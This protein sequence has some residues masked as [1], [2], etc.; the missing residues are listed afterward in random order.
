M[1]AHERTIAYQL[2]EY[3]EWMKT[4]GYAD[5]TIRRQ[6]QCMKPFLSFLKT[7]GLTDITDITY[8][9]LAEYAASLTEYTKKDGDPLSSAT[10]S[11]CITAVRKFFQRLFENGQ[12]LGDISRKLE[13]RP[14]SSLPKAV[15]SPLEAE[16]FFAVIDIEKPTGLRD[17]AAF[18]LVYSTGIR[19]MEVSNLL[20]TD[21]S[22]D[23]GTVMVRQGKGK[24][25]R[26]VP[27]GERAVFWI[28][29]YLS[30]ARELLLRRTNSRAGRAREKV[31]DAGFLFTGYRGRRLTPGHFSVL[32][33]GY[34]KAADIGKPGACHIFRHTAATEMLENGADLRYIQEMLGHA[35]METTTIYTRVS[36]RH[37]RETHNRTHPSVFSAAAEDGAHPVKK[38]RARRDVYGAGKEGRGGKKAGDVLAQ[39]IVALVK[40]GDAEA[41]TAVN[42]GSVPG[43]GHEALLLE[44]IRA[45]RH[46][47]AESFVYYRAHNLSFF[48]SFL[49]GRGCTHTGEITQKDIEEYAKHVQEM[50][51]RGRPIASGTRMQRLI[52]VREFCRW[53]FDEGHVL[54][55]PTAQLRLPTQ[56]SR[57]PADV[58]SPAEM[59]KIFAVPDVTRPMGL[60]DRALLELLYASGARASEAAGLL[61]SDLDFEKQTVRITAGKNGKDRIVP[62]GARAMG[63]LRRYL[64]EVRPRIAGYFREDTG[65]LFPNPRGEKLNHVSISRVS[66]RALQ[67]SG[68]GK[69]GGAHMFR[70][71][72]ATHMLEN[73]ADI[74]TIQEF[75]GH[76]TL[77]ATQ[78]YTRVAIKKLKEVHAQT[79]PAER[80]FRKRKREDEND[81]QVPAAFGN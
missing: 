59:E 42:A 9:H 32:G 18:E 17:R 4:Q 13:T 40:R 76:R 24:K 69:T 36:V 39:R 23:T 63:W 11:S 48:V 43:N 25:D 56:G 58:P 6:A 81:G 51:H 8:A 19:R 65:I 54:S 75:L 73:G 47:F 55:D 44:Y 26:V 62:A 16:R 10:I 61:V 1:E 29:R 64:E 53:L 41:G 60:R 45:N 21:V 50:T 80:W 33:S 30:G 7:R 67:K 70:H 57:L 46:R 14:R 79:H 35:G 27:L 22:L 37:L 68:T 74:R 12:I 66:G 52:A 3:L 49:S 78:V 77:L 15:L 20:V 72:A 31:E 71:A 34:L 5:A 28:T 2:E 38:A